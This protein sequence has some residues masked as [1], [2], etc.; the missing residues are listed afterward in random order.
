MRFDR[1]GELLRRGAVLASAIVMATGGCS[2]EVE[3]TKEIESCREY[4][5]YSKFGRFTVQQAGEGRRIQWGTYPKKKYSGDWYE[6]QPR[7][8]GHK[9]PPKQQNYAP[10]GSVSA[11]R[12][13][14]YSGK[15]F[16]INGT[17]WRNDKLVL[18][19]A[20]QCRVL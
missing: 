6:V 9:E 13:R 1:L 4:R 7:I 11:D 17:V 3:A 5:A 12:T 14:K 19:F 20:M 18:E 2:A 16:R 8:D 10:H 15:L